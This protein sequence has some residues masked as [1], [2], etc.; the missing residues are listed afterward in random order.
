VSQTVG[1]AAITWPIF[2][3]GIT[4]ARVKE[5]RQDEAQNQIGIDQLSLGISLQVRSAVKNLQNAADRLKLA[6]EQV[7][8]AE[9]AFR[10]SNVRHDAGEGIL[11]EVIDAQTDLTQARVGEV[12]ARYDYL[13]AFADL[14]QAI[15]VDQVQQSNPNSGAKK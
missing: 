8:V 6:Q 3:S 11:L 15:G 1:V 12:S 2:D 10:L 4:R 13:S 5:A 9:E 7:G 14:Q